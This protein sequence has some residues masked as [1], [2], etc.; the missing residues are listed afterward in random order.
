MTDEKVSQ[1]IELAI[2]QLDKLFGKGTVMRFNDEPEPWPSIE[3]GAFPLDLALGIGGLPRGRIVE[4]FGPES[5]GKST[6]CLSVIAEAQAKGDTCLFIDAEHSLD[7]VYAKA[8][9]VNLNDLLI[10]QPMNGEEAIDVLETMVRS[11]G[12]GVAVVDSVAALVPKA[13]IEG[14]M[15]TQHMGLQPRLMSKAIRKLYALAAETKTL[16]IFTNQIREKIGIMFGNPETQPGGR[17]LKFGASVRIDIRR[18]KEIK[19]NEG[20]II[21][22]RV[23]AKIIKNKMAPPLRVAEF[24]ILYGRGVDRVRSILDV[25]ENVGVLTKSS[26]GWYSYGEE[27]IGHGPDKAVQ[28]LGSDIELLNKIKKEIHENV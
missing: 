4:I 9:G 18:I 22:I 25:G 28:H 10:S 19:D 3:T 1:Q 12:V 11:R 15:D 5:S 7:P 21:G 2:A 16:I 17:A 14:D 6:L 8:L 13:E 24:N 23:K 27:K 26:N 20:N